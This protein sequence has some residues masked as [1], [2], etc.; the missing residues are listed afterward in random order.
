M[1]LASIGF[2]NDYTKHLAQ[3]VQWQLKQQGFSKTGQEKAVREQQSHAGR[4]TD[5]SDF[6]AVQDS[7]SGQEDQ[8]DSRLRTILYRVYAG[9]K[10]SSQDQQ[11]L[12]QKDPLTY[13]RMHSIDQEQKAYERALKRCRTKEDVQRLKLSRIGSSLA[14]VRAVEHNSAISDEKKL[15]I[16][17]LENR[18][19]TALNDSTRSFI[20]RGSYA[21]LPTDAEFLKAIKEGRPYIKLHLVRPAPPEPPRLEDIEPPELPPIDTIPAPAPPEPPLTPQQPEPPQSAKVPGPADS[22]EGGETPES[23]D[24]GRT[25]RRARAAAAYAQPPL[26]EGGA[27]DRK[28]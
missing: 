3:Q 12:L 5:Q 7:Q 22:P 27:L 17:L 20:R 6:P 15:K 14:T 10:L 24:A 16:I 4:E 2:I 1:D 28:A 11:Y 26:S 19:C 18:R 9:K 8:D 23:L 21:K 13:N 25:A